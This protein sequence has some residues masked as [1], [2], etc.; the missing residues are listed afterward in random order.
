MYFWKSNM[1]NQIETLTNRIQ[2]LERQLSQLEQSI[3]LLRGAVWLGPESEVRIRA[4]LS[5]VD[6][7]DKLLCQ[8]SGR[9]GNAFN[10]KI[11]VFN[12][13]GKE[14]AT[15]GAEMNG[16]FVTIRNDAGT[17]VGC[18]NCENYGARLL[19]SSN[20]E[21]GAVVLFGQEGGGGINIA[22]KN[23]TLGLWTSAE[24]G[25]IEL[26]QEGPLRKLAGISVDVQDAR[27]TAT[28]GERVLDLPI[29]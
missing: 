16:G 29:E 7:E 6:F 2:E 17:I 23:S 14:V 5:V 18:L 3:A 26:W 15:L 13:Q 1:D 25:E 20:Q 8:I 4:P 11:T 10:N 21:D 27:I 12:A 28:H 22:S 24:N 9:K 19:V